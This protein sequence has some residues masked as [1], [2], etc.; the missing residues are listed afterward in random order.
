MS[1]S[2]N[3][4]ENGNSSPKPNYTCDFCGKK[5]HKKSYCFELEKK[6]LQD[7]NKKLKNEN[8]QLKN[9]LHITNNNISYIDAIK[10]NLEYE[11]FGGYNN[12]DLMLELISKN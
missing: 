1:Q 12:V 4:S 7:E 10:N 2:P 8:K 5:G 9:E 6:Q 3:K 11:L